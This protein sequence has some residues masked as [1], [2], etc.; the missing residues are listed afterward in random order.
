MNTKIIN[1]RILGT[2]E[3]PL[4]AIESKKDIPFE[5]KRVYY[6]FGTKR[7]VSRGHHA[8]KRLEQVMICVHGKCR[9]ILDDGE[10][11]EEVVLD[12]PSKGL[13]V[14]PVTWRVIEGI[15][16]DYVLLVLASDYYDESDYIRDYN[17]FKKYIETI[18]KGGKNIR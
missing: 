10:R 15:T 11:N 18:N 3:A 6:L 14:G 2:K 8:H 4:I 1:F 9:V 7:N 16:D 5:I 12:S 17:E 13:Y